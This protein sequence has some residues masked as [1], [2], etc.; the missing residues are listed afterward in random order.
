M[1]YNMITDGEYMNT[2]LRM[3]VHL[4]LFMNQAECIDILLETFTTTRKA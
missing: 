2:L 3:L 4:A 1:L